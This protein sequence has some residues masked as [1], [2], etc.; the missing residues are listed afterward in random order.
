[1]A[2]WDRMI[3]ENGDKVKWMRVCGW[4]CVCACVRAW[5]PRLMWTL[6]FAVLY[7][8]LF[9]QIIELDLQVE[10]LFAHQAG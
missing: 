4:V 8:V 1:M 10:N 2:A 3:M 6:M 9:L 7:F 5:V